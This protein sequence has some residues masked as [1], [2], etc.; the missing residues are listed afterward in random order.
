[1]VTN[2]RV[3]HIMS[4]VL[5]AIVGVML[6]ILLLREPLLVDASPAAS[7][8]YVAA[9]GNDSSNDCTNSAAPCR[10]V[11]HAVDQSDPD[12]EILVATGV[13]TGVQNRSGMTQVVY[14]SQ[15]VTVR[16]GYSSDFVTWDPSAHPTTLDAQGQGRVVS[17]VGGGVGPTLEGFT[18]T[19]GNANGLTAN[20]PNVGGQS[21]GCG[22]GVFVYQ[23]HPI[24]VSNIVTN[25]VAAI[26]AGS[27][28]ASG[29]GLCLSWATGSVI[30]GNLIISNTA[31]L[32]NRGMGGG[33]HLYFPYDVLVVSN[34]VLNN[35][36]TTHGSLYGWGGGIAVGGSGA[37][38]TIQD[39]RI[40]GNR[41]NNG[42]GGQGAGIYNWYG[43]SHFVGNR[44]AGNFGAL[45]VQSGNR[46]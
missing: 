10:T 45:R 6:L 33:I 46:Q 5:V 42:N 3:L 2:Q 40:E 17:I 32:G 14:I 7:T 11:Q 31:S 38:A 27:H 28:S 25:N 26:S 24:I 39:N 37:V 20:C 34:Q 23:A 36:A 13:Y 16:G 12:D 29:G 43:G 4:A 18:I 41:T 35:T 44:V 30:T 21:D 19:G 1:M 15:T 22:G 9:A 8:R